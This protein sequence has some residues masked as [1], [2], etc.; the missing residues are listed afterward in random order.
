MNLATSVNGDKAAFLKT[1]LPL[2]SVV[3][4]DT[5]PQDLTN[6]GMLSPAFFG[7]TWHFCNFF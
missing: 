3:K 7:I 5:L 6:C 2:F 1:K 4:R